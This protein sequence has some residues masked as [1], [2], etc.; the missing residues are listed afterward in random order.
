MSFLTH[1]LFIMKY[2]YL[3]ILFPINLITN[4]R[5]LVT[6]AK[7]DFVIMELFF[8]KFQKSK[9][10]VKFSYRELYLNW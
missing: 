6:L 5:H 1:Y 4:F 9:N 10:N 7:Y 3:V 2:L 8:D